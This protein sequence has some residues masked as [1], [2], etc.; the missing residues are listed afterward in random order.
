MKLE[1]PIGWCDVTGNLVIGCTKV[2]PGC[3]HCYAANDTPARV[4][5]LNKLCICDG[6]HETAPVMFLGKTHICGI[7]MRGTFR[8][9]RLFPNSNSDWLDDR[10]PIETFAQFLDL[11]RLNGN[12][13]WLCLTKRP[14]LFHG[15]LAEAWRSLPIP[16]TLRPWIQEWLDHVR[17]PGQVWFGVS[18]EDQPRADARISELVGIPA[19]VR[20][21]SCEPL[22]GMAFVD[23]NLPDGPRPDGKRDSDG[24]GD[25]FI[26]W[27][28]IG[29]ES[30]KDRRNMDGYEAHARSLL[31]Q[32][33]AAGVPAYHKQM[34]VKGRVSHDPADW[35]AEF[36]VRQFPSTH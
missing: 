5:R 9:I 30:G 21:L 25:V 8:R 16:S 19:A 24:T 22:L 23:A 1:N 33:A 31:A 7:G 6:C 20:W 26:D 12:L 2:S 3:L 4:Q 15:R 18:V 35:P 27:L 17:H 28:V 34:P 13:D 10:W 36:R 29:C 32:C 11:I 14:E